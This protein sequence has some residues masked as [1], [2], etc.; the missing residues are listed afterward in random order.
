MGL[1]G[2]A[3]GKNDRVSTGVK[4]G[5]VLPLLLFAL[6][7]GVFYLRLPEGTHWM[8]LLSGESLPRI[9]SLAVLANAVAFFV[10]VR[11]DKLLVARGI[12][13]MTIAYAAVVFILNLSL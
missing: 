10:F 11:R 9:L 8:R 5:A 13:G 7:L 4:L 2:V 12:L 1:G 3:Q 6:L